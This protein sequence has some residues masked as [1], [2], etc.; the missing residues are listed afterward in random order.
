MTSTGMKAAERAEAAP[1]RTVERQKLAEAIVRRDAAN[2]ALETGRRALTRA[3][4]IIEKAET[5]LERAR[6]AV[7]DAGEQ[8]ACAL[9]EAI[10]A[11]TKLRAN[12]T[13]AAR[14]DLAAAEDEVAAAVAARRKLGDRVRDLEDELRIATSAVTDCVDGIIRAG[15]GRLLDEAEQAALRLRELRPLLWWMCRPEIVA[16]TDLNVPYFP[17][18]D[19]PPFGALRPAIERLLAQHPENGY[20]MLRHPVLEPWMRARAALMND[21]GA[22]LPGL[23]T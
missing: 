15:A 13:S 18:G 17:R 6:A 12:P 19:G 9:A 23:P 14:S 11:G 21:A 10:E 4:D 20:A 2:L 3:S 5:K 16:G 7:T 22:P 8:H 1:G